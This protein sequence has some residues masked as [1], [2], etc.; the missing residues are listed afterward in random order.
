MHSQQQVRLAQQR[1]SMVCSLVLKV[2][3]WEKIVITARRGMKSSCTTFFW[4]WKEV[5]KNAGWVGG[6]GT[7]SRNFLTHYH[8]WFSWSGIQ[9][10]RLTTL[11]GTPTTPSLKQRLAIIE[12]ESG[13]NSKQYSCY[14]TKPHHYSNVLVPVGLSLGYVYYTNLYNTRK[15]HNTL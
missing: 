9:S 4:Q 1:T 15:V 12:I 8:S 3:L 7:P 11:T 13:I 2:V 5:G 10:V 14:C 6:V